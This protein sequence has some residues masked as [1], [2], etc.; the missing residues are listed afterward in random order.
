MLAFSSEAVEARGKEWIEA[1][2]VRSEVAPLKWVLG[3][4]GQPWCWLVRTSLVV[5]LLWL[6]PK[7]MEASAG[8]FFSNKAQVSGGDLDL[9]G[10]ADVLLSFFWHGAIAGMGIPVA[11]AP[12]S[13]SS[14]RSLMLQLG[15]SHTTDVVCRRDLW[16]KGQPLQAPKMALLLPP[17]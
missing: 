11:A 2:L 5:E 17:E 12:G 16:L 6:E 1:K 13:A 15:E 14:R 7:M 9:L 3:F 10:S 8:A 4:L